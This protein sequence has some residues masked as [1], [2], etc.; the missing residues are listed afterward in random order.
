MALEV[1][2]ATRRG[3]AA[4]SHNVRALSGRRRSSL[5]P[6]PRIENHP[7]LLR[8]RRESVCPLPEIAARAAGRDIYLPLQEAQRLDSR[9]EPDDAALLA[10]VAAGDL[11]AFHTFYARHA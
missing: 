10:R 3:S 4:R 5:F 11:D 7:Q 2:G 6:L 1:A 9:G 8:A